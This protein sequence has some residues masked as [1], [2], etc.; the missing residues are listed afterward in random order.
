MNTYDCGVTYDSVFPADDE[1]ETMS[2]QLDY[3]ADLDKEYWRQRRENEYRRFLERKY[4]VVA[5]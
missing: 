4:G 2:N 5:Q 1:W 3:W